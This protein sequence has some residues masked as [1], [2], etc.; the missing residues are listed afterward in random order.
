MGGKRAG[1]SDIATAAFDHM[2]QNIPSLAT[3]P[4]L[5]RANNSGS[6][7]CIHI[8][9]GAVNPGIAG[10]PARRR[11]SSPAAIRLA[12]LAVERPSFHRMQGRS[13]LPLSSSAVAPCNCLDNPIRMTDLIST[14]SASWATTAWR[15]A[16]Q[17]AGSCS[18]WLRGKMKTTTGNWRS[19]KPV[20]RGLQR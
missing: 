16:T 5:V 6:L 11:N 19:P 14:T 15:A 12:H 9:S 13:T 7:R 10:F 1:D 8:S 20:N 2:R 18:G 4:F 3:K 17:S